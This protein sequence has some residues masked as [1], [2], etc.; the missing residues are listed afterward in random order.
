MSKTMCGGDLDGFCKGFG[1]I[2]PCPDH[3]RVIEVVAR[4]LAPGGEPALDAVER[5]LVAS[6]QAPYEDAIRPQIEGVWKLLE[7]K[8][9]LPED[10]ADEWAR[11]H[12][13]GPEEP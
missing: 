1:G 7:E 5:D 8:H 2:R 4:Y 11:A 10:D 13:T 3:A 6:R 12:P 9:E